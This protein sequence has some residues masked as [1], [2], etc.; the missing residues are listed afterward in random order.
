MIDLEGRQQNFAD[1]TR[2]LG[3]NT[4]QPQDFKHLAS[5]RSLCGMTAKKYWEDS[6]LGKTGNKRAKWTTKIIIRKT[7]PK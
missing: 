2:K 4:D 7:N 5:G 1:S 6:F 3:G